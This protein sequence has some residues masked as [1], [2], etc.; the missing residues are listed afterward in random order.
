MKN[1]FFGDLRDLFKYDLILNI[2]EKN[3]SLQHLTF[4][5]M[6]NKK[7]SSNEGNKRDFQNAI[8]HNLPGTH[9]K[10]LVEF[11]EPYKSEK[12]D[13][14]IRGVE[15]FTIDITELK[16][17]LEKYSDKIESVE[18]KSDDRLV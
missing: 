9:N 10:E 14:E 11:L 16:R 3:D 2:L 4:I 12:A 8:I 17:L 5:P 13:E 6:L 15:D 7:D 18:Y 1:Q